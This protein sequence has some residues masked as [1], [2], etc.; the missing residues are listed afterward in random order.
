MGRV[1]F[2]SLLADE[3]GGDMGIDDVIDDAAIDSLEYFAFLKRLEDEFSL[4]LPSADVAEA[5]TFRDLGILVGR[6]AL[7][8]Q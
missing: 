3:F 6:L 1:T 2:E 4:T 7:L 5:K 8:R